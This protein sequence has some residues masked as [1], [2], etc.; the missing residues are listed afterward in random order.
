MTLTHHSY[1]TGGAVAHKEWWDQAT[2]EEQAAL[3]GALGP[4]SKDRRAVR[5]LVDT[6]MQ[7][8]RDEGIVIIELTPEERA[9]WVA[10]TQPLAQEIIDQVGG[11]AQMFYEAILEG[12]E[13]FRAM[14]ASQG[15][16]AN[17][18]APPS[19]DVEAS[20]DEDKAAEDKS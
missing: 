15:D 9:E 5:I 1:D 18:T 13:A 20:S 7:A 4:A 8:F 10:K 19:D 3:L 12:K 11:E 6:I 17:E 2:P 14:K 16:F